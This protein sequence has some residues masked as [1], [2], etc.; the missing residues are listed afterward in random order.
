MITNQKL[1]DIVEQTNITN[2]LNSTAGRCVE[3]VKVK[4][5][6]GGGIAITAL[7]MTGNELHLNN[8][9]DANGVLTICPNSGQSVTLMSM[10]LS[11]TG[12]IWGTG[13]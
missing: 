11:A 12:S 6:T 1:D 2:F 9:S 7:T 5:G 3:I 10:G 4:D 8:I 13:Y